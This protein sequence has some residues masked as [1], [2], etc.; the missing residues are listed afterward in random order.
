MMPSIQITRIIYKS[1]KYLFY[2]AR[3]SFIQAPMWEQIEGFFFH[4]LEQSWAHALGMLLTWLTLQPLPQNSQRTKWS[5]KRTFLVVPL[6]MEWAG[7]WLLGKLALLYQAINK[8][9]SA[10]D[11]WNP[12]RQHLNVIWCVSEGDTMIDIVLGFYFSVFVVL[13]RRPGVLC[14]LDEY[15]A[16][17]SNIKLSILSI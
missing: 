17:R 4:V 14:S 10:K 6:C 3:Q 15:S 11:R 16:S 13:E 9:S 5:I 8:R 2:S 12:K 7:D 1:N